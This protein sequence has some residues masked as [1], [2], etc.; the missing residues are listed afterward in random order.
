MKTKLY[1][2]TA[3]SEGKA[4]ELEPDKVYSLGRSKDN[5]IIIK[6]KNV[7]RYHLKIQIKSDKLFIMD[8]NSKNGTFTNGKDITPGIK[9]EV[10]EGVPIVI[11][12][13]V[14]GIG[15][16]S[17]SS[18]KPLLKSA[19]IYSETAYDEGAITPQR[20]NEIKKNLECIYK[21]E[22][23][24]SGST[25]IDEMLEMVSESIID[26]LKRIDKCLVILIDEKTGKVLSV[27]GKSR[28]PDDRLGKAYN[29]DLVEKTLMLNKPVMVADTYDKEFEDDDLT[30]SLKIM[31]I[32]SAMCVPLS[33]FSGTKGTIY[34]DSSEMPCG[35]R[36]ND[37]HLLSD[38]GSRTALALDEKILNKT[39]GYNI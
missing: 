18:I 34:V 12:M 27:I 29:K 30:E 33:N 15:E 16:V 19:G 7:S 5:D 3:D 14:M 31:K 37:L 39:I 17:E 23:A 38:I 28:K 9:A 20:V 1:I 35:F 10:Q 11:G 26:L 4:F 6:D 8:L 24:F 36:K 2:F 21:V 13:T 32:S 22:K 25:N